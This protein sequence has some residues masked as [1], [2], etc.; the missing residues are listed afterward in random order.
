MALTPEGVDVRPYGLDVGRWR[1]PQAVA[2]GHG[3][4]P[5]EVLLDGL[6]RGGE[7]WCPSVEDQLEAL[8]PLVAEVERK[9]QQK[10]ERDHG[11]G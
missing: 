2:H 9:A 4:T 10:R 7:H 1:N 8:A 5:T 3:T 11:L 6:K